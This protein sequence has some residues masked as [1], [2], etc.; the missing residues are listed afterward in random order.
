[1]TIYASCVHH[2]KKIMLWQIF[3]IRSD[4]SSALQAHVSPDI[5]RE[6]FRSVHLMY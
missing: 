5:G 6:S 3:Q 1:M 2:Q 4:T